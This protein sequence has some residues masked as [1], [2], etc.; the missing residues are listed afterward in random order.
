MTPGTRLLSGRDSKPLPHSVS[1]HHTAYFR[2]QSFL[3][4]VNSPLKHES[5]IEKIVTKENL[6]V[7]E[8]Y[9]AHFS[10]SPVLL[11]LSV[12]WNLK[13]SISLFLVVL[14]LFLSFLASVA[15]HG[16][17]D[18]LE[19]LLPAPSP[20]TCPHPVLGAPPSVLSTCLCATQ[21][22]WRVVCVAT[23][24]S[25]M[26]SPFL[27]HQDSLHCTVKASFVFEAPLFL[28]PLSSQLP[29]FSYLSCL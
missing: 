3:G 23:L 26:L 21:A 25:S 12:S 10:T 20:L 29:L 18:P 22:P 24:A 7:T 15:H 14:F 2:P 28:E 17:L 13:V 1:Y 4:Q 19:P 11:I 6:P 5:I 9:Y 27:L 16:T 8:E